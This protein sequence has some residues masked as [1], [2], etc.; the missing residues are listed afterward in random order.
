[1]SPRARALLFALFAVSG[2]TGLIYESLW[3]QY[4]K[5]FLGHAAYAQA[6]V[7][8]IFMGGLA[9]GSWIC[10]R[11]SSGW[12]NLLL[13]Y[14]VTEAAVGACAIAFHPIFVRATGFAYDAVLPQLTPA[15]A[16]AFRWV[17]SAALILP[18]TILL[19]MTFPLMVAGFVRSS[20]ATPGR[21]VA[22]LYF[23]NSIGA[24]VRARGTGACS[25]S[26]RRPARRRSFTRW[27]GSGCCASSSGA[28][29]T[30]SSSC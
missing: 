22:L 28:R 19:G 6:L 25:S 2:F 7:L 12:R 17:L 11:A 4:L 3:T 27:A 16:A 29:S 8:A 18:Q 9:L 14:A 15:T 26:R 1:M 13:G 24:A 10:S 23:T 20:P 21:S 5:L 30:R